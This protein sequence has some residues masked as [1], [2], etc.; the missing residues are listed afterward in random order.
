MKPVALLPSLLFT[1]ILAGCSNEEPPVETKIDHEFIIV[2]RPPNDAGD[3]K[4]FHAVEIHTKVSTPILGIIETSN[5]TYLPTMSSF[6]ECNKKVIQGYVSTD[7]FFVTTRI[8][9][10]T[11]EPTVGR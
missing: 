5:R 2:S 8:V 7:T 6:P 11:S 10:D 4:Y 1:M 3:Q 9:R